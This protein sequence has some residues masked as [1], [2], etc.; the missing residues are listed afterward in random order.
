MST[1]E[2]QNCPFCDEEIKYG[3]LKCK[4]CHTLLDGAIEED[5]NDDAYVNSPDK[6]YMADKDGIEQKEKEVI[7]NRGTGVIII[8]ILLL[9]LGALGL[10]ISSF[11][12][13]D[14]GIAAMIG[15]FS[16]ILSGIGFLIANRKIK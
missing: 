3:A 7:K 6:S 10:L 5:R 14:I 8:G 12:F 9:I 4:H 2:Y 11:M 15:A 1:Q 13:G 16:A